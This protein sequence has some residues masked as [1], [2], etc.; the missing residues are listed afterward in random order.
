MGLSVQDRIV[1]CT[2]GDATWLQTRL[3]MITSSRI[4][5]VIGKRKRQP[6]EGPPEELAARWNLKVEIVSERLSGSAAEHYVSYWMD[7]GRENEPLALAAYEQLRDCEV[8]QIGFLYHPTMEWGGCSPD[9][10]IGSEGLVE[11]KCPK[12]ATHIGYL[13]AQEI[14]E[15][16]LPQLC[17]QLAC[18]ETRQWND[19]IS[20]C[21]ELPKPYRIFRK[22]LERTAAVDD[23]IRGME[24]EAKQFVSE[25]D[26]LLE[27]LKK[28]TE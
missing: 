21:P 10:R 26:Q 20:Y 11:A 23:T 27:R 14:P 18:D 1:S 8:E 19:F 12:L 5:A 9:G 24:A 13:V 25:V 22:R 4:A 3:G 2:Q 28:G 17:W 16:Y 15:I 7:Q 6:K